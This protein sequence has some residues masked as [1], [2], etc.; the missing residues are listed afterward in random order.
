LAVGLRLRAGAT[1]LLRLLLLSLGD[2]VGGGVAAVL[3]VVAA[4]E[5]GLVV[6][7]A[8]LGVLAEVIALRG[9]VAS[10]APL[11]RGNALR[12]GMCSLLTKVLAVKSVW[13]SV[14]LVCGVV[15]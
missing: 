2:G 5:S 15:G 9:V 4:A 7:R 3:V 12:L 13:V 1:L 11:L 10:K 8:A 6:A 14:L